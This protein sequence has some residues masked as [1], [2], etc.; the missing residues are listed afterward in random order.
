MRQQ[1]FSST[2]PLVLEKQVE[3]ARN[4]RVVGIAKDSGRTIVAEVVISRAPSFS[5]TPRPGYR[6]TMP[7]LDRQLQETRSSVLE[8]AAARPG[9]GE[10]EAWGGTAG[11]GSR[12]RVLSPWAK[13]T[14][15]AVPRR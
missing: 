10:F 4:V 7:T 13:G 9:L 1:Y 15:T 14:A 8:E 12:A 6:L 2:G 3:Y 11:R 5:R